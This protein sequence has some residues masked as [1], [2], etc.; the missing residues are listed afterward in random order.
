M[1]WI[2]YVK[3]ITD[4]ALSADGKIAVTGT[5]L[6]SGETGKVI[7]LPLKQER[8]TAVCVAVSA[9][10][11]VALTGSN[12]NSVRAWD[13]ATGKP[14]GPSLWHNFILYDVAL[15]ADGKIALSGSGDGMARV[16]ETATGKPIGSP[17]QFQAVPRR[18]AAAL[19]AD[20]M[21][22]LT[23]CSDNAARVW[24]TA[25]GKQIGPALQHR[26]RLAAVAL[27]ARTAQPP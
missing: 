20:G 5:T 11:K 3:G 1:Q 19:S 18:G 10:G 16:W 24:R 21:T 14:I 22:A 25:T 17:L 8:G 7:G 13:T 4:V 12:G 27:S 6:L 2:R 23:A 26:A 9:D 15:S